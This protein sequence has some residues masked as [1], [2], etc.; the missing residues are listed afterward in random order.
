MVVF[1]GSMLEGP[2]PGQ[3]KPVVEH[4]M[5]S[6]INLL[7]DTSVVVRDTAAW[8]IGRI[9]ELLPESVL[10][11][12]ILD[13]LINSLLDGLTNEPR[14]ASNVCWVSHELKQH[15]RYALPGLLYRY[16][17]PGLL[18]RYALPGCQF[19]VLLCQ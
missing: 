6:L 13:P 19:F 17:L 9:C 4:A 15:Y 12:Q 2:D 10:N 8:T 11:P 1:A 5:P 3:L 16:A 18:Y 7:K 14:V